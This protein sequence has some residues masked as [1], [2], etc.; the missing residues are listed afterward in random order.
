MRVIPV[1]AG[2][3]LFKEFL[4]LPW[5]IYPGRYPWMPLPKQRTAAE[6]SNDN[7]FFAHGERQ[8]FLCVT[9]GR[10]VGRVVASIDDRRVDVPD[11]GHFGYFE[12]V[13]SEQVARTLLAAAE[14]WL[15]SKGRRLVEGPID[16]NIW[17]RYRVQLSGFGSTPYAGE[18]RSPPY[19]PRLLHASGYGARLEW[20]SYEFSVAEARDI[21]RYMTERRDS[22]YAAMKSPA[23]LTC[24]RWNPE[25]NSFHDLHTVVMA[26]W[27]GNYGFSYIDADEFAWTFTP[28][29]GILQ[30][31]LCFWLHD[32][33]G[34]CAFG[35][36]HLD[37][38]ASDSPPDSAPAVPV[39]AQRAIIKAYGIVPSHRKTHVFY[40]IMRDLT[41]HAYALARLPALVSLAV[42][43]TDGWGKFKSPTRVH[44]VYGKT[45]TS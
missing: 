26:S 18:P 37:P 8:A 30:P 3:V 12:S 31:P 11:V 5:R 4:E 28:L 17:T 14:D 1:D 2:S 25:A 7:P 41:W 21:C 32:A 15:R 42:E 38:P 13:D 22:M 40:E 23:S 24:S 34:T 39:T 36:G 20:R 6:L 9:D 16:L 43:R 35:L 44:A 10:A 29:A 27:A 19:Y 45:L 33:V